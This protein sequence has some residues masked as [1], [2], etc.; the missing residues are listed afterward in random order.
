MVLGRPFVYRVLIVTHLVRMKAG[1]MTRGF[2]FLWHDSLS[3][4]S[5][6]QAVG[7]MVWFGQ[8]MG[9][10]AHHIPQIYLNGYEL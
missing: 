10:G 1:D 2:E 7:V 4:F 9:G 5:M 6:D 8:L 3:P